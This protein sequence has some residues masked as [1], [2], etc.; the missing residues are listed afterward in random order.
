MAPGLFGPLP[1]EAGHKE[2][3][4]LVWALLHPP[5]SAWRSGDPHLLEPGGWSTSYSAA[6]D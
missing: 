6:S 5:H 3:P 4:D 2:G 1:R